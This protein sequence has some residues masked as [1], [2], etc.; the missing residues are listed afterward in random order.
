VGKRQAIH[1]RLCGLLHGKAAGG[2]P[3]AGLH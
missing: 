2:P 3:G 1:L